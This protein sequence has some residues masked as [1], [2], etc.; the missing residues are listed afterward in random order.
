M[1]KKQ[2]YIILPDSDTIAAVCDQFA[3]PI[4][5]LEVKGEFPVLW[6][7]KNE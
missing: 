6:I 2:N 7:T 3:D 1:L 5:I 4:K